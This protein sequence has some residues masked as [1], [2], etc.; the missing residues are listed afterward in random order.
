MS[1][2]TETLR[3]ALDLLGREVTVE[4]TVPWGAGIRASGSHIPSTTGSSPARGRRTG[5]ASMP[6]AAIERAVA[7]QE[8]PHLLLHMSAANLERPRMPQ[9]LLSMDAELDGAAIERLVD[10]A[11]D[12]KARPEAYEDACRRKGLLLLLEKTSTRTTLSFSAAIGKLGGYATRL[13]WRDSNFSISPLGYE[14]RYSSSNCDVIMA[15]LKQWESLEELAD[16]STVPVING[17]DTRYHPSQ[18]VADLITIKE[19]AGSLEGSSVTYVGIHNNVT[20]SL[21]AAATRTGVR[22][23]LVTPL[24]NPPAR[25]DALLAR[26]EATGLVTRYESVAEAAAATQFIYT[27]TWVDMEF[28]TDPSYAEERDRRIALMTPY[29]LN[30]ENLGGAEPWVMH[31]MPIHP[32]YEISDELVRSSRSVIFQQAENRLYAAMAM[33]LLVLRD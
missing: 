16:N 8:L 26:A 29:Q 19:V 2:P 4:S 18:A 24:S 30:T 3:A 17:C 1:R 6:T 31:D 23:G 21:L 15:R 22:V 28:F 25:D 20:N 32:G 7:F 12:I 14:A 10:L 11:I 27:D 9:H 5:V 13:D 33:L